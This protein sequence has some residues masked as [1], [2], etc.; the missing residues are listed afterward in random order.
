MRWIVFFEDTPEML[1]I[2]QQRESVHL[3]YLRAH[4]DEILL[5]GGCR[6]DPGQAFVGGL[7]V[8]EVP[9]RERAVELI[10]A[11]P[12]YASDRRSYKI[13]TWGKALPEVQV[14]L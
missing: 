4:K 1:E 12:Y 10:E 6:E 11:D 8:L 5:G 14:A 3:A 7:W 9:S 13:R 2:R